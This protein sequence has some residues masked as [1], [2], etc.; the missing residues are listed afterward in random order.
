MNTADDYHFCPVCDGSLPYRGAACGQCGHG[1]IAED[2]EARLAMNA[3][4]TREAVERTVR[5]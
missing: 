5:S 2:A 4:I 3:K 1:W